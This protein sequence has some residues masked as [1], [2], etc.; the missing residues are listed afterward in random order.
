MAAPKGNRNALKHGLYATHFTPEVQ[1]RLRKMSPLDFQEEISLMRVV[2]KNLF[3]VHNR[4][5]TQG[6]LDVEEF[7]KI[8]N[9]LALAVATLN[10]AVRSYALFHAQDCSE[11]N[12]I[13]AALDSL[14]VFL[15][16]DYVKGPDLS[17]PPAE[18]LALPQG[19]LADS[20]PPPVRP[21]FSRK[22][23][24]HAKAP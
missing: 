3:E 18:I 15:E 20:S 17:R 2:V 10:A 14:P 4:L 7:R 13:E 16:D 5:Y 21:G 19:P 23:H 1:A 22:R 12:S 9:S 8:S 24:R 11:N 6:P